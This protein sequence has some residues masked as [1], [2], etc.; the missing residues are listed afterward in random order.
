V[1]CFADFTDAVI[2]APAS[3]ANGMSIVPA[4]ETLTVPPNF[5]GLF[6]EIASP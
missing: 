5:A 2:A 4:A 1:E 6:H 3:T